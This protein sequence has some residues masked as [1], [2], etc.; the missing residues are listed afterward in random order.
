MTYNNLEQY[1]ILSLLPYTECAQLINKKQKLDDLCFFKSV[2]DFSLKGLE[3]FIQGNLSQF[4]AQVGENL[5]QIRAYR[6]VYIWKS[7]LN[8]PQLKNQFIKK[9]NLIKEFQKKLA[10]VFFYWKEAIEH[11][12]Y[13]NKDLD[14]PENINSFLDKNDIFLRLDEEI[15]FVIS[16]FFLT[17]FNIR[18]ENIPV[19]IDLVFIS[20]ELNISKYR[21]KRLTHKYQKTVCKLGCDFIIKISSALGSNFN[22]LETLPKLYQVSDEDRVV[23]P[24]YIAS[25]VIFHHCIKEKI[26]IFLCVKR[27]DRKYKEIKDIIYFLLVGDDEKKHLSFVSGEEYLTSYCMVISGDMEFDPLEHP[28]RYAINFLKKDPLKLILANTATHPQYSGKKLLKY[29]NDPFLLIDISE[30]TPNTLYH[31]ENLINMKKFAV[32][33]GCSKENPST[34][35]LRHIYASQVAKEVDKLKH[36]GPLYEAYKMLHH[37]EVVY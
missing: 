12:T 32:D 25:E 2:I 7:L 13:Y 15:V 21:A 5:C 8:S 20:K 4:D 3:H 26:P 10:N 19:A 9:V 33:I 18:S 24:C 35:F 30:H 31:K 36:N 37:E 28:K 17:Y 29:R 23:L 22:Y 1:N 6:I 16:C 34:F 27:K 11:S 14:G